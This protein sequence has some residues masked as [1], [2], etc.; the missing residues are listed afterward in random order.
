M[1]GQYDLEDDSGPLLLND[2]TDYYELADPLVPGTGVTWWNGT[3][4]LATILRGW[5]NGSS[6]QPVT[7]LGT[8]NG[9]SIDPI[10]Q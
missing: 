1:A 6:E 5:W 7:L 4:R 9:T 10:I 8:W 3:T 2:L